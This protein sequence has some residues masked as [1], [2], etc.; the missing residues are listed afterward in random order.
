MAILSQS[1][2]NIEAMP[3]SNDV[4][5]C[6]NFGSGPSGGCAPLNSFSQNLCSSLTG[7][8]WS[9]ND[10]SAVDYAERAYRLI[11]AGA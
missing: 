4:F 8:G 7:Q 6:G 3:S 10:P 9:C 11:M 1:Y 5:G 2:Q